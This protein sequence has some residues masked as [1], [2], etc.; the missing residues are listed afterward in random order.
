MAKV[1]HPLVVDLG[2]A[3][4]QKVKALMLGQGELVQDVQDALDQVREGLGEEA[5]GKKLLPVVLVYE[6]KR[7]RR[8]LKLTLPF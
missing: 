1:L 8:Y 6:R 3:R 4:S 5:E 7:A 2:R